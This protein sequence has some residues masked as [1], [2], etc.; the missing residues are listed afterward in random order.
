MLGLPPDALES[1]EFQAAAAQHERAVAADSVA[2]GDAAVTLPP[3]LAAQAI[4][5]AEQWALDGGIAPA[6]E[7]GIAAVDA[8]A[9]AGSDMDAGSAAGSAD[10]ADLAAAGADADAAALANAAA[11][12]V[13]AFRL[14]ATGRGAS[15]G[16]DGAG[17][18]DAFAGSGR[19][20]DNPAAAKVDALRRAVVAALAAE[21]AARL[22]EGSASIARLQARFSQD[23]SV[24][25][26]WPAI[27]GV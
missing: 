26:H 3:R 16:A 17:N 9:I 14:S 15:Q 2:V 23:I 13:A 8:G 6:A 22:P 24:L 18:A 21:F 10:G 7:A 12:A 4:S 27:A 11:A 19:P 20:A 25:P 5:R 1:A